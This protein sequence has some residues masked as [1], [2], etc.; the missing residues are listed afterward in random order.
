MRIRFWAVV[1]AC[2]ACACGSGSAPAT[3][4]SST[5]ST[6]TPASQPV[7]Q[8]NQPPLLVKHLGVEL[9]SYDPA[10]MRAGD[11]VFTSGRLQFNR[12]WMDFGFVIPAGN[13]STGADKPNPQPTFILPLGTR[14]H[15]LV[16]GVVFAVPA[17]YSGDFSIQ[18]G[19][20]QNSQWLYETEHVLNPLV[21]PGDR[22]QAGQVIAEVSTWSAQGNSGLGMVEIGL[23]HGGVQPEHVCP[24]AYLDPSIKTD[25]LAKIRA[26]YTA[27]ESFRNDASLYD[28]AGYATPGCLTLAAIQ[29]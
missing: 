10:T 22:V 12:I 16:D 26:L 17:L 1:A 29:G 2:A 19:D 8:S 13:S 3:S 4:P 21:K 23:L 27:W 18:V 14:V 5:P 20:G 7:A 11:F 25:L 9:D 15:S 6:T 24:F 28:E